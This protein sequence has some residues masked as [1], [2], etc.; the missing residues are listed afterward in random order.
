[1]SQ[2]INQNEERYLIPKNDN[3][4]DVNFNPDEGVKREIARFI[5]RVGNPSK[6]EEQL[7]WSANAK[8]EIL[9]TLQFGGRST[10]SLTLGFHVQQKKMESLLN[11]LEKEGEIEKR[12]CGRAYRWFI[13]DIPTREVKDDVLDLLQEDGWKTSFEIASELHHSLNMIKEIC[14]GLEKD[15]LIKQ[16]LSGRSKKWFIV[17]PHT[18]ELQENDVDL[19]REEYESGWIKGIVKFGRYICR[20]LSTR[21]LQERILG[22][23]KEDGEKSIHELSHRCHVSIKRVKEMCEILEN[24]NKIEKEWTGQLFKWVLKGKPITGVQIKIIDILNSKG[25]Q[26]TQQLADEIGVAK[27]K[28]LSILENIEGSKVMRTGKNK[29]KWVTCE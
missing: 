24:E 13:K 16:I 18:K 21:E 12:W 4:E 28:I 25:A 10:T 9:R 8:E 27:T 22:I 17:K 11:E 1:M 6:D 15:G 3:F 19:L 29:S 26:T 14:E 23:L 20:G 7:Q 5:D 2:N